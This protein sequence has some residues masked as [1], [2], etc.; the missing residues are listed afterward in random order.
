ML[1]M[2]VLQ[3]AMKWLPESH[4]L[5]DIGMWYTHMSITLEPGTGGRSVNLYVRAYMHSYVSLSILVLNT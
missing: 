4:Q 3:V 5:Q 1:P 2:C